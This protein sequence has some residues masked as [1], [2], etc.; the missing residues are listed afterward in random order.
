[1]RILHSSWRVSVLLWAGP[2]RAWPPLGR[3]H[4]AVA[5]VS[6]VSGWSFP[7]YWQLCRS[8]Q[9]AAGHSDQMMGGFVDAF[10][11]GE[12]AADRFA[13]VVTFQL[14]AAAVQHQVELPAPEVQ[15][16]VGGHGGSPSRL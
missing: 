15:A 12:P 13:V 11:G 2:W 5:E 8:H 6:V 14:D 4:A 1:M 3:L 16:G 9:A 7:G 10:G